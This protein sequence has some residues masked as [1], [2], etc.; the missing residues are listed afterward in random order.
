M[1]KIAVD[2]R[3]IDSG[4]IGTYISHIVPSLVSSQEENHFFL[5]GDAEHPKLKKWKSDFS[6]VSL[7]STKARIYSIRE[8][9]ELLLK[10]PVDTDL[11]FSPHF[12]IS[13]FWASKTVCTV[14]DCFHLEYFHYFSFFKK[15]YIRLI[16]RL[17]KTFCLGILTVSKFSQL[18]ISKFL[19]ISQDKITVT[20]LGVDAY[21]GEISLEKEDYFLFV[22]NLKPHK[23]IRVI[24]EALNLIKENIPHKLIV[25]GSA[26]HHLNPDKDIFKY[27]ELLQD[28]VEFTGFIS[29]ER[30][31]ELYKRASALIFPSFYEGFGLPALEAKSFGCPTILSNIDVFKEVNEL[32]SLYFN[33]TDAHELA[34]KMIDFSTSS[35]LRKS[36]IKEGKVF[37]DQKS[38]NKTNNRTNKYFDFLINGKL[39]QY[40]NSNH[41]PKKYIN[42]INILEMTYRADTGGGPN[43]F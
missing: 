31:H 26:D 39:D 40:Y 28:R 12:N 19:N 37:S 34:E 33:S 9:I 18:Q 27:K 7:I 25:V 23:N 15:L 3:M 21:D 32:T 4:G 36:I 29:E 38:W 20:S 43:I 6:N 22:G 11:V 1:K 41:S 24:V 8:Q 35:D 14:H 2:V 5:L 13:L 42:T 10:I 16:F 17:I 30:L